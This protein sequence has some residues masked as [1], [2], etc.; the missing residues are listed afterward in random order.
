MTT[1]FEQ[2]IAAI[3]AEE[4]EFETISCAEALQAAAQGKKITLAKFKRDGKNRWFEINE[5]GHPQ[6]VFPD[7]DWSVF[8][9]RD[10]NG[11]GIIP[12]QVFEKWVLYNAA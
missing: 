8:P 3:K 10:T 12:E 11:S 6:W 1:F 5:F 9:N 2:R 4:Y 7:G